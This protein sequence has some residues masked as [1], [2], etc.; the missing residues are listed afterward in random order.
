[1][2]RPTTA[3]FPAGETQRNIAQVNSALPVLADESRGSLPGLQPALWVASPSQLL[4]SLKVEGEVSQRRLVGRR[5][6]REF[7]HSDC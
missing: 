1:M 2:K 5:S 4:H 6:A 3:H 7:P